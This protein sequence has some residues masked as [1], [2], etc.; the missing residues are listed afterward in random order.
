VQ[1]RKALPDLW[2]RLTE[3]FP[4]APEKRAALRFHA[5]YD[6]RLSPDQKRLIR[7]RLQVIE[8]KQVKPATP[9]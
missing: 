5:D 6:P 3:D 2:P 9:Q 1:A 4:D 8:D 7:G